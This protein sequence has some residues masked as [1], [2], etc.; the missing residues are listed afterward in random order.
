MWMVVDECQHA[1][2]DGGQILDTTLIANE[3]VDE[4][5]HKIMEGVMCKLDME[6]TY[7]HIKLGLS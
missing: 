4:L 6:K 7:Y 2:V 3:V 1:F 5:L